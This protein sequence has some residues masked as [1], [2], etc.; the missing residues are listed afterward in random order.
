MHRSD[1]QIVPLEIS[2]ELTAKLVRQA[3]L[4]VYEG[5]SHGLLRVAKQRGSCS[6]IGAG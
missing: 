3:K 6:P 1:D 5:G 4:S 2:A